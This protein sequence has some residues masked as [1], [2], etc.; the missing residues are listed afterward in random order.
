MDL[1][2]LLPLIPEVVPRG[3]DRKG[4]LFQTHYCGRI[5]IVRLGWNNLRHFFNLVDWLIECLY[6]FLHTTISIFFI[7]CWGSPPYITYFTEYLHIVFSF[8]THKRKFISK[9]RVVSIHCLHTSNLLAI[10]S[11][12]TQC[13]RIIS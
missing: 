10:Q 4:H 5:P 2:G 6:S 1:N 13:Y 8:R 9:K 3:Q 12:S 7:Q 11:L